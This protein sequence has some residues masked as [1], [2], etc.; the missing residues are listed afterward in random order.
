LAKSSTSSFA[1]LKKTEPP[2]VI[3]VLQSPPLAFLGSRHE[4]EAHHRTEYR[5]SMIG[6]SVIVYKDC[7][8]EESLENRPW[9][10]RRRGQEVLV[11]VEE[12]RCE[13]NDGR[14][15]WRC[16]VRVRTEAQSESK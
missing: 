13:C 11:V 14:S 5:T 9:C 1:S 15:S 8:D 2:L 6:Y 4:R 10:S 3:F 7:A 12:A 16:K